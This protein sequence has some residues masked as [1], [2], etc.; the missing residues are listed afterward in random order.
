MS[1]PR[2]GLNLKRLL[3][4]M[5]ESVARCRLD[6][7]GA[8][9][10]TEAA[11]GAYVVTPVLAAMAGA[12]AVY[13]LTRGTRYG[14]VEEITAR[15]Q[16]LARLAGVEKRVRILTEK[17]PEIIARADIVTNSGHVR[18][19][20]AAMIRRMKPTAVI[21]LMYEAWEYRAADVDL[22]ACRERG[23][24]VA[25]TN[26]RHPAV[27]VFSFLGNM[28]VKLLFDAGIPVYRSKLLLLCDN[29][30]EAHV[31]QGLTA[32]GA[33][34]EIVDRL[35]AASERSDKDA[36]VVTMLPRSQPVIGPD[37]ARLIAERWP[38]AVVAQYW[39][40]VD[41]AAL[42]A[43][44][45]PFWPVESPG[46]GHMGVLPS[47]VGPEAIVRLQTGGLKVGEVLWRAKGG[48]V[49]EGREFVD[50]L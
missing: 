21:P 8:T 1:D 22:A 16:E 29:P 45:V 46:T 28:A 38:G 43:A 13:A 12:E 31:Y 5:R 35:A 33:S 2:P 3:R 42:S 26:E 17:D 30:F 36:I 34:V 11:S 14:S 47:A 39:G 37:E 4:L 25:G 48:P 27:D 20:D 41:R 40:D 6:L 18:P 23:I 9:V 24:A 7:R 32:A 15:T 49:G 19:I 44:G 10:L 50:A